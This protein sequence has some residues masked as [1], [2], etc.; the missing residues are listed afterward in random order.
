VAASAG[1]D[2][3]EIGADYIADYADHEFPAEA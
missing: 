3:S 1:F 2:L